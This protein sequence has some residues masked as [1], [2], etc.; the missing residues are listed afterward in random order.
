MQLVILFMRTGSF[1][2]S[3]E[4][5]KPRV[6]KEARDPQASYGTQSRTSIVSESVHGSS[7]INDYKTV[8]IMV[9]SP[10]C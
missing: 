7:T 2:L 6:S 5:L 3:T 9:S 4:A 8:N 10:C 1:L